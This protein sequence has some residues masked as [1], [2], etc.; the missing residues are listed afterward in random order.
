M[1]GRQ[2]KFCNLIAL[3]QPQ[4]SSKKVLNDTENN[5]LIQNQKHNNNNH[6]N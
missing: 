5:F 4:M 2:R 1:V 3:K 6:R